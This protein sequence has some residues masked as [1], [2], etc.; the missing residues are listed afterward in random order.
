MQSTPVNFQEW[1]NPDSMETG[2]DYIEFLKILGKPTWLT[3]EGKDRSRSRAI[4]T[5][6]HG[7]EPSGLKAVHNWI[8]KQQQPATDLGI[9]VG[10][11]NAALHPPILSHRYLPHE[12]D[13]NRCFSP[14]YSCNQGKLAEKVI[15]LLAD[16]APEAV[17]DTHN[18]SA[19]S[20]AFAVAGHDNS[21]VRQVAQMFTRKLVVIHRKMGTLIETG[22]DLFPVVTVEFGGFRDPRSDLLADET[23]NDFIHRQALFNVEPVP[24]QILRDPQRLELLTGHRLHYSSTIQDEDRGEAD[25]TIFNTIDQLNFSAVPKDT[26]LGWLAA[27]GIEGL[28]VTDEA[29]NNLLA[30]FFY[31]S[32]GFLMTKINMNIFM[33]TTDAYIAQND[34]LLYLTAAE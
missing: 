29:G 4:V 31:E 28:K 23:L 17:V 21:A 6:L 26:S 3:F 1:H 7:N 20:E 32:D 9:F 8:K 18:T 19:H 30:R 14:P 5:L 34:C 33:A 11:V 15:G 25:I 10:S 16:F 2:S 12:K 24:F 22:K 27:D 13:F